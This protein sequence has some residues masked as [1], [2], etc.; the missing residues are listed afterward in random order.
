MNGL[1]HLSLIAGNHFSQTGQVNEKVVSMTGTGKQKRLQSNIEVV[2][3]SVVIKKCGYCLMEG[4]NVN[5]CA[6]KLSLGVSMSVL[7]FCSY[8]ENS[9]PYREKITSDIIETHLPD[10]ANLSVRGLALK[11]SF[12]SSTRIDWA[13]IAV[14]V[15]CPP[16]V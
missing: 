4:H 15:N 11:S 5:G 14:L 6:V 3:R 16:K 7:D 10:C 9:C 12:A 13:H 8:I 1:S 2:Q